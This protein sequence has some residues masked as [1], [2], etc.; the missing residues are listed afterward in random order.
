MSSAGRSVA[1][2]VPVWRNVYEGCQ[3]HVAHNNAEH[4]FEEFL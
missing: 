1:Y 2:T 4:G 3:K